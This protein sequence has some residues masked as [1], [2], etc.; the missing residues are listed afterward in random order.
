M[1]RKHAALLLTVMMAASVALGNGGGPAPAKKP[2]AKP[3]AKSEAKSVVALST[4]APYDMKTD[5]VKVLRTTNKAQVNQYVCKVYEVKN[6]NPY[7]IIN[8]PE[9]LAEG[10]EGMIYTFVHP[11]GKRGKIL[12]TCPE[13]QIPYFDEMIA[14]LDRKAITSAPGSRYI[15]Y[16]AKN[17]TAPF[18]SLL[19]SYY[20]GSQDILFPDAETNSVL[21][22]GVPSGCDAANEAL[23]LADQPSPQ[24]LIQVTL[25]EV[26]LINDLAFGKDFLAWK[27][28]PGR[29]LAAAGRRY[30][31]L[32][33]ESVDEASGRTH[34]SGIFLDCPSAYFDFLVEK[35]KARV[36]TSSK[37]PALSS[38]KAQFSTGESILFYRVTSNNDLDRKVTGQTQPRTV[39]QHVTPL[40]NG[41][42][43]A[44][45]STLGVS[46]ESP[47]QLAIDAV[48]T[49]VFLEVVPLINLEMVDMRIAASAV[50]LVGYDD[51]G[52]PILSSQQFVNR[53]QVPSGQEVV[54]GG[55]TRERKAATTSKVPI[56]GSI[57]IL[58]YLFGGEFTGAEKTMIVAVVKPTVDRYD[59]P[60]RPV[61]ETTMAK[62]TGNEPI[63][64]PQ[65]Q[66]GFDMWGLDRGQ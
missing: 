19:G 34:G 16:R 50:T 65:T 43:A 24:A 35:S 64:M 55:L 60:V 21:L 58:G 5:I 38:K 6:C 30:Q 31:R 53:V 52:Q 12:V 51:S 22:F 9:L 20:A 61:D 8:F 1:A 10:E 62:A 37:L 54:I 15:L 26:K 25:Y 47:P 11:D 14:A 27:N 59:S 36:L 63:P 57:P 17:R 46:T 4:P 23:G 33:I 49:G 39:G 2:E 40:A 45:A 3:A 32:D 48:R 7:E 66:F 41:A 56:L 44:A 28:G 18:L 42:I 13:Y 29:A